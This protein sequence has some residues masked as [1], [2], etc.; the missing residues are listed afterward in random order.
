MSQLKVFGMAAAIILLGGVA[1]YFGLAHG[2]SKPPAPGIIA[3]TIS[4]DPG[5]TDKVN[6]SAMLFI[7]A[8]QADVPFGPPLAVQKIQSPEFPFS[9][10]LSGEDVMRP[11][12][13]FQGKVAVKAKLDG[14]GSVGT[15]PGYLEGAYGNN[16]ATVGQ[17]GAVNV[18]LNKLH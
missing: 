8:R 7:I 18:T 10:T 11:G 14:D 12:T 17:E 6:A 2:C 16:P 9:Y 5:L 3:G 13:P 1:S 4:V 15:Q